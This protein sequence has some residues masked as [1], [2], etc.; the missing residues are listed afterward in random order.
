MMKV[1]E[2]TMSG[3]TPIERRHA[4]VLGRGAWR[5]PG[6]RSSPDTP[7]PQRHRRDGQDQHLRGRDDRAATSNGVVGSKVG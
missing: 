3:L 5:G 1:A 4:R 2:I 6:G 7:W